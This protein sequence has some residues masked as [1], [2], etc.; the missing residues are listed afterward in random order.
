ME[1]KKA[2]MYSI[3]RHLLSAGGST[4]YLAYH[5]KLNFSTAFDIE[6]YYVKVMQTYKFI[7]K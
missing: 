1:I 5:S 7:W 3:G 4:A 2:I 6:G